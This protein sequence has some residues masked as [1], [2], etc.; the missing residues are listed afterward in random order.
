VARVAGLRF[1]EVEGMQYAFVQPPSLGSRS[2]GEGWDVVWRAKVKVRRS[3]AYSGV[4]ENIMIGVIASDLG[5]HDITAF[6][7][8]K[9]KHGMRRARK[10]KFVLEPRQGGL[11]GEETTGRK[12]ARHDS[13][14]DAALLVMHAGN[15]QG[16]MKVRPFGRSIR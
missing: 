12:C 3:V 14:A 8:Q 2:W 4:T 1:G 13:D 9:W 6:G 11:P 15:N 10:R 16:W 7:K 5:I